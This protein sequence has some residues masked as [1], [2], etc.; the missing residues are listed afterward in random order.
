MSAS[1]VRSLR[2]QTWLIYLSVGALALELFLFDVLNLRLGP[3]FNAIGLSSPIV[4]VIAVRLHRP[5]HR[6]PWYLVAIGQT[7][8]IIGDVITYNYD[9]FFGTELPYPSP[10]DILYLSVYPFLVLGILLLIRART[11]GSDRAS[12][13]DS[14]IIS[15]GVGTLSWVFLIEPYFHDPT[16][17]LAQKLV[18][19]SYPLMDLILLTVAVRMTVGG[20]K[21]PTA[22]YLMVS[23]VAVLF[24]TD[25]I[26]GWLVLHG[27]YDNTT[28]FLEGGWGLFYLLWGAAALHPSMRTLEQPAAQVEP[29]HPRRRILLLT[30]ASLVSPIVRVIESVRGDTTARPVLA[31]SSVIVF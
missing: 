25:S 28:G 16:L 5:Q 6:L 2:R 24:L 18:A 14:L 22:F 12:L 29:K 27:G 8:F 30:C 26:Y 10:G 9:R 7:L 21:R 3:L 19:M 11:P 13:I 20:G 31:A 17:T 4:I 15:I 1:I 23:S